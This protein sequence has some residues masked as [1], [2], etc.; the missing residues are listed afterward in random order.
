[1]SRRELRRSRRHRRRIDAPCHD[2]QIFFVDRFFIP[3]QR[4]VGPQRLLRLAEDHD[5]RC[6]AVK[7]VDCRRAEVVFPVRYKVAFFHQIAFDL[8]DQR[9]F[10]LVPVAVRQQPERLAGEQ[11]LIVLVEHPELLAHMPCPARAAQCI[12]LLFR[13]IDADLITFL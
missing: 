8:V 6:I 5:A 13:H 12:R 9:I 10:L 4:R 1:M 2:G 11:H 3:H 7:P